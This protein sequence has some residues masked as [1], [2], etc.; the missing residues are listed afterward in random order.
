MFTTFCLHITLNAQ[1]GGGG[2]GRG[3]SIINMVFAYLTTLHLPAHTSYPTIL[4]R[5]LFKKTKK[6]VKSYDLKMGEGEGEIRKKKQNN[7]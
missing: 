6:K 7:Y 5:E 2:G 3:L 1:L 4:S